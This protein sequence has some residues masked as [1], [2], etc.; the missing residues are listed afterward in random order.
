MKR[1]TVTQ[2]LRARVAELEAKLDKAELARQG[3]VDEIIRLS[4]ALSDE[5][6][7][8]RRARDDADRARRRHPAQLIAS[9]DGLPY[10][11]L[12]RIDAALNMGAELV[13]LRY[14]PTPPGFNASTD[15][16]VKRRLESD[17][18]S[19]RVFALMKEDRQ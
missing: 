12:G 10:V 17:L 19:F 3:N 14:T 15:E 18:P 4:G 8:T 16:L 2:R 11:D 1:R 5:R 13:V 7:A 6:A 9:L